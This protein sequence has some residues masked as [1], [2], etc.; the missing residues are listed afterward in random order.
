MDTVNK[1]HVTSYNT[2]VVLFATLGSITY[3]YCTSIIATTLG[4]PTFLRYFNLDNSGNAAAITGGL[5]GLYQAG[6]LF[7]S[8]SSAW[9]ADKVG[10]RKA[11]GAAAMTCIL[12]GALQA[13]SAHIAMF[14]IARFI[15]GFGTGVP[16]PRVFIL[17]GYSLAS[18][19]GVG[20]FFVNAGGAQWR[21]PLAIQTI[22]PFLLACGIMR[23]PESPRWLISRGIMDE[24]MDIL[25]K[26]HGR[27]TT[28]G[29]ENYAALEFKQIQNQLSLDAALPCSW[30]SLFTVPSYRRRAVVGFLVMFC[31]QCTG[32]QVINNYGPS[33]YASIGFGSRDQLLLQAGWISVGI[34]GNFV[35]ALLLDHAGRKYVMVTGLGGTAVALLGEA[36][37]L[38]LY[39]G[40]GNAAGISAAVFFLFLHIVFYASC[41]DASTYVYAS[42]IWPTH[43]RSKGTAFS[44]S[45]MFLSS[46][47]LL[48]VS[49]TAF[50]AIGWRYYL[51]LMSFT[52]LSIFIFALLF[53][54]T[55]GLA[56]EEV[57][58]LFKDA[59]VEIR[60]VEADRQYSALAGKL[61]QDKS[62]A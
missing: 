49:P 46:L 20:F 31:A 53:P 29:E 60:G 40:S 15:T 32:T 3:G 21:I 24:A 39:Q 58:R 43:I 45:G 6:G 41:L 16:V 25:G 23:L 12:G 50:D 11:I 62:S 48:T 1:R 19:V 44:T 42:E 54:E 9:A 4:Q 61:E 33:L 36:V 7:G 26:L 37:M 47:I 8:L 22:P 18:W 10:R 28:D 57:G 38:A 59:V 14:M 51:V 30:V 55:K 27:P 34:I 5:N 52:V 35:N 56:L 13:G 2:W 17:V